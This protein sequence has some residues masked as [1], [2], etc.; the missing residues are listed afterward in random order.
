MD[1][2]P[3]LATSVMMVTYGVVG[4]D[5]PEPELSSL[6]LTAGLASANFWRKHVV[7]FAT[8]PL[9]VATDDPI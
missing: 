9:A 5:G 8:W 3:L 1:L 2:W 6:I 4:L 7:T